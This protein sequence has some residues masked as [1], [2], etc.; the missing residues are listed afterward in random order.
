MCKPGNTGDNLE[1]MG[2]QE[3]CEKWGIER[4]DQVIDMLGLMGDAS[5]NIPGVPGIGEKTAQKLIA[6]FGTIEN[7]LDHT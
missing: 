5:D 1:T 6:Q 2:V 7:L 4:V 3:I